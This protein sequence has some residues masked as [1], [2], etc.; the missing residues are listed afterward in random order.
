MKLNEVTV[1]RTDLTASFGG[2]GVDSD[3]T[4]AMVKTVASAAAQ[5]G[6][7]TTMGGSINVETI[8]LLK[9]DSE[10]RGLIAAVETRKCVMPVER[11][12]EDGA[13]DAAFAVELALLDLQ[14]GYH[15][16]I[17]AAA[18]ARR[19]QLQARL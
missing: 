6:M 9:R 4:V 7:K 12:L 19:G 11:F 8:A 5:R 2:N 3:E 1:G 17:A 16:A 10:L 13:L 14:L 18:H 15:D